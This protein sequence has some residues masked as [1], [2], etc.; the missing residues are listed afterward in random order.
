MRRLTQLTGLAVAAALTLTACGRDEDTA[1][2]SGGSSGG[3]VTLNFTW[4]GNDDRA[5]R[6]NQAIELF[7]KANPTITVNGTFADFESYWTAR[8]TEAAGRSLPDLM[9]TDLSYLR[10]YA[11]NGHLLDLAEYVGSDIDDSGFDAELVKAGA[12]DGVQVG[13]PTSTNTLALF[14]NET[15]AT[16]AGVELPPEDYTWEDY[17]AWM[18]QMSDAGLQNEGGQGVYGGGDP[19]GTMWRFIQWL[20]QKGIEPFSDEGEF[21]FTQDDVEEY[22]SQTEELRT[23]GAVFPAERAQQV[24]P[25]DGFHVKEQASAMTWDNFLAGYAAEVEG[26]ITILPMPTGPEGEKAMFWKPSMLLSVGANTEHPDEA[27]KL[28]NFLVTD[29][30]V[31]RIFGTSKGVP[32]DQAQREAMDVQEGTVDAQ[33]TAFEEAVAD[34]VTAETPL[35]IK[36]FGAIESEWLRL[37]EDLQYGKVTPAEFAEQWWAE[38][39]LAT[40]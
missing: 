19:A 15:M 16:Q 12:L 4:W 18:K 8:S 17:F 38:A 23:S 7:E 37:N 32:A 1:G 39:E 31:G 28:L 26:P 20:V 27:V 35:P 40:Q 10:E 5:T 24:A 2:S 3:P 33:V 11:E 14:V 21:N 9:Q 34:Q 36:G 6:Y 29:P 22:V 13:I 30:E 25:L